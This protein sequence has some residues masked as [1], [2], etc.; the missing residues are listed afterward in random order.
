M[1]DKPREVSPVSGGKRADLGRARS[2]EDQI[3]ERLLK[4][5]DYGCRNVELWDICHAVTSR[6]SGLRRRGWKIISISE[7]RGVWRYKLLPQ[8]ASGPTAQPSPADDSATL[9][10]FAGARP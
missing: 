5:G 3:L 6:I 2:Q 7:G 9:P 8:T 10:L 1:R 4:A